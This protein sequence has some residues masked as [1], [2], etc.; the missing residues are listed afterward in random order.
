M[1][2]AQDRLW[3]QTTAAVANLR[4]DLGSRRLSC[5]KLERWRGLSFAFELASLTL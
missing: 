5:G 4:H 1:K 2:A 3:Y